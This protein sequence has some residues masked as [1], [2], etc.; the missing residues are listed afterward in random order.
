MEDYV[1]GGELSEEEA[2]QNLLLYTSITGP[3][4]FEEALQSSKW[5]VTMN[6]EIEAI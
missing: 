3:I 5:R 4:T 2:K 1:S 6:M